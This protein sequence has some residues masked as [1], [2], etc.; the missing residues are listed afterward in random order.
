MHV[1]LGWIIDALLLPGLV[2]Q[3]LAPTTF[4]ARGGRFNRTAA[5]LPTI[6][7]WVCLAAIKLAFA[8]H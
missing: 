8:S 4:G 5:I 3:L 6:A 7:I 1:R 2:L